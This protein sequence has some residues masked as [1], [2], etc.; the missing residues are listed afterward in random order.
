[1]V[2]HTQVQLADEGA[3]PR[4]HI[5]GVLCAADQAAQ[6]PTAVPGHVSSVGVGCPQLPAVAGARVFLF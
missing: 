1:M 2:V 6:P 3:L 4:A 5:S